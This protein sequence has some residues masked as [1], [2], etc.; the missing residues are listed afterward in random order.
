MPKTDSRTI[1]DYLASGEPLPADNARELIL[2]G[3]APDGCG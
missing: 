1:E 2:R 3:D